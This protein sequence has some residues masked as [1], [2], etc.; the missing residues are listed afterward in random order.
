M[1]GL[2][3]GSITCEQTSLGFFF[4]GHPVCEGKLKTQLVTLT[5]LLMASWLGKRFEWFDKE[6]CEII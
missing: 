3:M 5:R 6:K 2:F 1:G 4:M